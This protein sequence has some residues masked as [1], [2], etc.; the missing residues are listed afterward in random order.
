MLQQRAFVHSSTTA[1]AKKKSPGSADI[2]VC[3]MHVH[4]LPMRTHRHSQM[5]AGG[6][7]AQQNLLQPASALAAA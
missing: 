4:M 7:A 5:R 2:S 6:Q 3:M 1:E